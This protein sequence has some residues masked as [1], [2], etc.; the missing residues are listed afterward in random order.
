M[1]KH[2]LILFFALMV[3]A[4][5]AQEQDSVPT[6]GLSGLDL[7]LSVGATFTQYWSPLYRNNDFVLPLLRR[8]PMPGYQF[9]VGVVTHTPGLD[10]FARGGIT[11]TNTFIKNIPL[12][13][14]SFVEYLGVNAQLG[15]R[16]RL[17][18]IRDWNLD[19]QLAVG[20]IFDDHFGAPGTVNWTD[21][22]TATFDN[23][24]VGGVP[25]SGSYELS[26]SYEKLA[27]NMYLHPALRVEHRYPNTAWFFELGYN[28]GLLKVIDGSFDY[29]RM[30]DGDGVLLNET[31]FNF[32]D[33]MHYFNFSFGV[34]F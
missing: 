12:G 21:V 7:E 32:F 23:I 33:R 24:L 2:I 28:V 5:W 9:S 25:F 17:W 22:S 27:Y 6:P 26:Y 15:A 14:G 34:T 20:A 31:A 10:I 11:Y 29:V 13:I 3:G 16:R 4:A 19:G 30:Y 8:W 18:G 1:K